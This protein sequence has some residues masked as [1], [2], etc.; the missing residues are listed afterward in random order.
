MMKNNKIMKN[1]ESKKREL[2]I[3]TEDRF[4]RLE[5]MRRELLVKELDRSFERLDNMISTALALLDRDGKLK[6]KYGDVR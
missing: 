3:E 5:L 4:S 6:Q 2:A 1:I